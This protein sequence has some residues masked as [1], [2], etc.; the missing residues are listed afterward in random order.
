MKGFFED[1]H[2]FAICA[3]HHNNMQGHTTGTKDMYGCYAGEA[4][5]AIILLVFKV[6]CINIQSNICTTF[7]YLCHEEIHLFNKPCIWSSI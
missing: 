7:T 2:L 3:K 4:S 1:T 5:S 6:S